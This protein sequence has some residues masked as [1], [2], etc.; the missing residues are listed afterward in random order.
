MASA[1]M[2][3]TMPRQTRSR[4]P[5]GLEDP[6]DPNDPDDPSILLNGGRY[7]VGGAQASVQGP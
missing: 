6:C 1:K 5:E 3:L 4:D 2:G 7:R